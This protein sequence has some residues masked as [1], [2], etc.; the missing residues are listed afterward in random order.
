MS[1]RVLTRCKQL[2]GRD[3]SGNAAVEFAML[4]PLFLVL[5]FAVYEFGRIYWL[6][7]TLQY[8]AEQ[9]ARCIMAHPTVTVVTSGT[10][11]LSN[12]T[13]GLTVTN[14]TAASGNCSGALASLVPTPQCMTVTATY[15][16]PSSDPLTSVISTF[17]GM[18]GHRTPANWSFTLV[19]QSTV[20]IS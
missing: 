4:I 14:P 18:V 3:C 15:S 1:V 2:M 6:Q 5:I 11:A 10:C 7:N 20:P 17:L 16:L 8:A 13:S 19:G 12:N 9:T